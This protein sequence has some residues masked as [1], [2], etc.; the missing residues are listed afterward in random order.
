M[1]DKH[2]EKLVRLET[3]MEIMNEKMD[4]L[5]NTYKEIPNEIAILKVEVAALKKKD[6][7]KTKWIW[8]LIATMIGMAIKVLFGL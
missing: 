1:E 4:E 5:T 8:G 6:E 3:L 7:E 2:N